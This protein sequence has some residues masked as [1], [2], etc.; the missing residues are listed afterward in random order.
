VNASNRRAETI[1]H[2]A[3]GRS[4][5][6]G[7]PDPSEALRLSGWCSPTDQYHDGCRSPRCECPRHEEDQ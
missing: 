1:Q 6:G 2:S 5:A 3:Q 7:H 4:G